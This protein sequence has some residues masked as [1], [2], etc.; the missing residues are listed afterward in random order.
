MR[1]LVLLALAVPSLLGAQTPRDSSFA[2][3]AASIAAATDTI[4]RKVATQLARYCRTTKPA[5]YLC[6][7]Q[8]TL[9]RLLA[10]SGTDAAAIQALALPAPVPAPP[11]DTTP[12]V[13]P[14]VTPVDT[15]STTVGPATVA[16]LPRNVVAQVR[17]TITRAVKVCANACSLQAAMNTAQSGD[18]L[19]LVP[20]A[21][22][23][24]NHVWPNKG[25]SQGWIVIRTDTTLSLSGTR[26][27]PSQAASHRLA[28]IKATSYAPAIEMAPGAHHLWLDG[29]EVEAFAG[30]M[31]PLIKFADPAA[32]NTSLSAVPHHLVISRSYVHGVGSNLKRC[33]ATNS[34]DTEIRDS[35]LSECRDAGNDAQAIIGWTGTARLLVE[36]NYLEASH[37]VVMFGGS[38][39]PLALAP[40]DIVIRGNHITRP[41]SWKGVQV[42]KNLIETKN[43]RR[44]LVEGNVIEHNWS[45]G[46][47]GFGFVL[48]SENQD[49]SAPWSTTSDVTIRKNRFRH[50]TNGFKISGTGSNPNAVIIA[51]RITITDNVVDGINAGAVSQ[52]GEGK[53]FTLLGG[54]QDLIV[55]HNTFNNVGSQNSFITFGDPNSAVR[56]AVHSN[57]GWRGEYGVKGTS[58][59]SGT[60]SL[61]L[62]APGALFSHN[63][64]LATSWSYP[65]SCTY[66]AT[67]TCATSLPATLPS[68][69]D[70]RV[71]G[72]DTAAVTAATA[73]AVVAP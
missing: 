42:V 71:I 66:P 18:E 1:R 6:S 37:E 21:V 61:T 70:A 9:T 33:V 50:S 8:T 62:A 28:K 34:A 53:L 51:A 69:W 64:L 12:E 73:G 55:A 30:D 15:A 32:V 45:S 36:N 56:L 26:M 59:S 23:P 7:T 24:G 3:T 43:A 27:T 63:L 20:G 67:T 60:P 25:A 58:M 13:P 52:G 5:L 72:A 49:N 19:L 44:M 38:D 39:A 54:V 47:D 17:P 11:A 46:Q 14:E 41:L 68:G 57:I 65:Y 16:E 4:D 22:Y 2:R 29:V 31:N 48:K 40:Q 35:W 10:R